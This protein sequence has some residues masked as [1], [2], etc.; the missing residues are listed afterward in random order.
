MNIVQVEW[1][2]VYMLYSITCVLRVTREKSSIKQRKCC[3]TSEQVICTLKKILKHPAYSA[4]AEKRNCSIA[5]ESVSLCWKKCNFKDLVHLVRTWA[6][7]IERA[8]V[9][10]PVRVWDY[11]EKETAVKPVRVWDYTEKRNCSKTCESAR[12]RLYW[13]KKLQ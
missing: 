4:C 12:V 3:N 11:T 9:V 6:S 1:P 10:K 7:Y 8:T 13:K 5:C 2:K